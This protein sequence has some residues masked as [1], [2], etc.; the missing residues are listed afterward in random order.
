MSVH[1]VLIA[2]DDARMREL[3]HATLD[4]GRFVVMEA[5]DGAAALRAA[6]AARPQLVFLDWT[7]PQLSGVEVCRRLRADPD[8][9]GAK[10]VM[11][12]ARSQQFDRDAAIEAGVDDY[13]T[14]P[15]S[16][17]ALLE[18]VRDV[19]GPDAVL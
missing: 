11:L 1:T 14:K 3:V 2:D 7:M 13:F 19:L 12:T 18:K 4:T 6:R 17:L 15:F 8:T 5:A 9:A 16:P 10:I